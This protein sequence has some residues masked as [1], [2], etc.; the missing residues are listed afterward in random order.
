MVL[1]ALCCAAECW[2]VH[3][4][5]T[6]LHGQVEESNHLFERNKNEIT[7]PLMDGL[8]PRLGSFTCLHTAY[9]Y[10]TNRIRRCSIRRRWKLTVMGNETPHRE[11][12]TD[13]NA[14]KFFNGVIV[15]VEKCNAFLGIIARLSRFKYNDWCCTLRRD[16]RFDRKKKGKMERELRGPSTQNILYLLDRLRLSFLF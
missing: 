4:F 13:G 2:A 1:L 6:C 14:Y 10:N 16:L 15:A 11:N 7:R 8:L 5:G 3:V 12:G 9:K